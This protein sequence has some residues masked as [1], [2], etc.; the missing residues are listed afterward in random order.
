MG[1]LHLNVDFLID[2]CMNESI[3][4]AVVTAINLLLSQNTVTM[5]LYFILSSFRLALYDVRC[6]S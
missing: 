3:K 6:K 4:D 1:N 5:E 2:Y